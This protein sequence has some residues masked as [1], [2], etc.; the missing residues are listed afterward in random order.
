VVSVDEHEVPCKEGACSVYESADKLD[1]LGTSILELA[2]S[3]RERAFLMAALATRKQEREVPIVARVDR[4]VA[5][6]LRVLAREDSVV[7]RDVRRDTRVVSLLTF[8]W[9]HRECVQPDCNVP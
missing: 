4:D 7:A 2:E 6:A 5:H 1:V 9:R 8:R 3:E